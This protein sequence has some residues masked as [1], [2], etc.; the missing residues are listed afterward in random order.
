MFIQIY[1][2]LKVRFLVSGI[3]IES[4]IKVNDLGISI[5]TI[6]ARS[7]RNSKRFAP[8]PDAE[9]FIPHPGSNLI[10]KIPQS[11]IITY[12]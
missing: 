6:Q 1:T 12:L 9:S 3:I 4:M 10:I 8:P 7:W 5:F 11:K 2:Q